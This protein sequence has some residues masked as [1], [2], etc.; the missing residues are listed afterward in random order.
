MFKEY[1]KNNGKDDLSHQGTFPQVGRLEMY[2]SAE[3]RNFFLKRSQNKFRFQT[4]LR[5]MF[6][7]DLFCNIFNID[8]MSIFAPQESELDFFHLSVRLF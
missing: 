5:K 8:G 7:A 6:G 2:K 1:C 3:N 4:I